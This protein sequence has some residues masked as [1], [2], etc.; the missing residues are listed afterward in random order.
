MV[1]KNTSYLLTLVEE[2]GD[3]EDHKKHESMIGGFHSKVHDD[4]GE[5]DEKRVSN[6]IT[7]HCRDVSVI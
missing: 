6:S 5:A 2:F 7:G 1:C 4:V 3:Q